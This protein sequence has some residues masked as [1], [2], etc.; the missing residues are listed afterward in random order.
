MICTVK[1]ACPYWSTPGEAEP[2]DTAPALRCAPLPI[3]TAGG[4]RFLLHRRREGDTLTGA[5]VWRLAAVPGVVH[6]PILNFDI[7]GAP[8]AFEISLTI[9]EGQPEGYTVS[10]RRGSKPGADLF[11]ATFAN[12]LQATER[13]VQDYYL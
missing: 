10:C 1:S 6:R 9:A 2:A 13:I 5:R 3:S 12:A 8:M 4:A 11:C 7:G